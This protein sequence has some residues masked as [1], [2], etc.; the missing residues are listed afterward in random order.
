M[1]NIDGR[2]LLSVKDVAA[3]TG[4]SVSRVYA[5]VSAGQL[6]PVQKRR[7]GNGPGRPKGGANHRFRLAVVDAW[8]E[9]PLTA[10]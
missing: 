10:N 5:A 8:L 3:Y 6:A 4:Y 9:N 1:D 7:Y 2:K